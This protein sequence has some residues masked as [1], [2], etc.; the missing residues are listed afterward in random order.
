MIQDNRSWVWFIQ[1]LRSRPGH[2]ARPWLKKRKDPRLCWWLMK[3]THDIW[4]Q[5]NLGSADPSLLNNWP[6][7]S[8]LSL[9]FGLSGWVCFIYLRW[10]SCNHRE[11][12]EAVWMVPL[13]LGSYT[14][15]FPSPFPSSIP[16]LPSLPLF[17]T[18]NWTH[19]IKYARQ[20]L[21]LLS[22]TTSPLLDLPQFPWSSWW[23]R[24]GS[25]GHFFILMMG[26]TRF[27]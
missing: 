22:H 5:Q 27:P 20:V 23:R 2:I 15:T 24:T 10:G 13:K 17:S 14:I 26:W 11:Q 19:S 1:Q 25:W 21:Y 8:Q 6:L 7:S 16:S 18:E 12:I 9:G 4:I 3:N